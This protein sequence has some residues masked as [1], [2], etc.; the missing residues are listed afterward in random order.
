MT[1]DARQKNI[2]KN[3]IPLNYQNHAHRL[4]G[5]D[6]DQRFIKNQVTYTVLSLATKRSWKDSQG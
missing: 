5:K 1:P 4:L 6:A 2:L 3:D